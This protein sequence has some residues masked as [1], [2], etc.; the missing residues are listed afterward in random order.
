MEHI[1]HVVQLMAAVR[2]TV[3]FQR[4]TEGLAVVLVEGHLAEAEETLRRGV[5]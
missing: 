2:R 3:V 4:R 5:R 1:V